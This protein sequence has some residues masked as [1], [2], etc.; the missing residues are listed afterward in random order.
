MKRV[1]NILCLLVL[2]IFVSGYTY[3]IEMTISNDNKIRMDKTYTKTN[4]DVTKYCENP[5]CEYGSEEYYQAYQKVNFKESNQTLVEYSEEGSENEGNTSVK[6]LVNFGDIDDHVGTV[7]NRL[8]LISTDYKDLLFKMSGTTYVSNM[9]FKGPE[10]LTS[11]KFVL[12][13]PSPL[14]TS[15]ATEK[16]DD[17]NTYTWDLTKETKIDF[18]YKSAKAVVESDESIYKKLNANKYIMIGLGVVVSIVVIIVFINMIKK[19]RKVEEEKAQATVEENAKF[20]VNNIFNSNANVSAPV[21]IT[22]EPVQSP[23]ELEQPENHQDVISNKFLDDSFAGTPTIEEPSAP[24][25]PVQPIDSTPVETEVLPDVQPES[26]SDVQ[27]VEETLEA[28][29]QPDMT[30]VAFGGTPIDNKNINEIK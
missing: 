5:A 10:G 3:D 20:E 17:N 2:T 4:E 12:H 26:Q 25:T 9:E 29:A 14:L 15:N 28:P 30:S 6:I 16:N 27:P 8:N 7:Y 18:E 11:G 13:T 24:E 21:S 22:Q 19:D 23:I 1:A